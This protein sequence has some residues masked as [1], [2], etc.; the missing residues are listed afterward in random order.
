LASSASPHK[1]SHEA[2]KTNA[3]QIQFALDICWA[4]S[5]ATVQLAFLKFYARLYESKALAR[6][7]CYATMVLI[8]GW[9]IYALAKWIS[10]CHPPGKCEPQ[11]KN[12]CIVIGSLH[13]FFNAIILFAPLPA[14]YATKIYKTS[15]ATTAILFLLGSL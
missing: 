7:G 1:T 10:F 14:I 11:S 4:T 6:T 12:S 15:K 13:V 2:G 3:H 5:V 9:Y 8:F